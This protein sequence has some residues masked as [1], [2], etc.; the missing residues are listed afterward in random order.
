MGHKIGT[1]YRLK[2]KDVER[3]TKIIKTLFKNFLSIVDWSYLIS[4][5]NYALKN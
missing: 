1:S 3:K 2:T 5:S 4:H